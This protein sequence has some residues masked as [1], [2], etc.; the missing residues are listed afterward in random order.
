MRVI[1]K[2]TLVNFW[3]KHPET[4]SSLERWLTLVEA[5]DWT[6][7]NDIRAAFANAVVLNG[8]RI[9]FEVAGGNYRMIV[10]IAFRPRIVFVKFLGTHREYDAIDALTVANF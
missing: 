7:M 2:S 9:R 8:E 5:S 4:K 3:I 6:S 10:S 1:A